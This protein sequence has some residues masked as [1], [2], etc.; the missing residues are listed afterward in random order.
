MV[1][2]QSIGKAGPLHPRLR[3]DRLQVLRGLERKR[4]MLGEPAVE[5]ALVVSR[6]L[7]L[8]GKDMEQLHRMGEIALVIG[9]GSRN[10]RRRDEVPLRGSQLHDETAAEQFADQRLEHQNYLAVFL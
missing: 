3:P 2:P 9:L 1:V 7:R 6:E 8:L 4:P 5:Y 10:H